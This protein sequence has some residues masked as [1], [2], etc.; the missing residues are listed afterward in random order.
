MTHKWNISLF[1]FR[2]YRINKQ[3]VFYIGSLYEPAL[4]RTLWK[5]KYKWQKFEVW[6]LISTNFC[7]K[8]NKNQMEYKMQYNEEKKQYAWC[9][10]THFIYSFVVTYFYCLYSNRRFW[11]VWCRIHTMRSGWCTSYTYACCMHIPAYITYTAAVHIWMSTYMCV[12]RY[13]FTLIRFESQIKS[14]K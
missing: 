11:S 9:K 2:L 10:L 6:S 4:R 3:I 8:I 1:C 7:S 5:N 13:W 14:G 12:T